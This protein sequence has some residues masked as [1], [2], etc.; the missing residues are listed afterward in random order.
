LFVWFNRKEDIKEDITE[1]DFIPVAF[2]SVLIL[3]LIEIILE[4]KWSSFYFK[5]GIPLYGKEI[6][7]DINKLNVE[8]ITNQLNGAF[9][10][11]WNSP[12]M[13]FNRIDDKTIAFRE[14]LFEFGFFNYGPLMHGK[15]EINYNKVR[16][17]GLCNW[18]P[19]AFAV[20]WYSMLLPRVEF[21]L[22]IIFL[23]APA[24]VYGVSYVIQSRRYNKIVNQLMNTK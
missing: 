4:S 16:I 12:T 20:L 11:T 23:I 2:I 8:H 9:I 17:V 19:L 3:M 5:K 6:N 15:I 24:L 7:C 1:M 18:F 22:D 14:K 10:G 13:L 21:E